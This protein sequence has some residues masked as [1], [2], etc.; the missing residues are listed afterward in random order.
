MKALKEKNTILEI[1]PKSRTKKQRKSLARF[2]YELA[3]VDKQVVQDVLNKFP[4]LNKKEHETIAERKRLQ[5]EVE[6]DE[7]K[8]ERYVKERIYQKTSRASRSDLLKES[9]NRQNSEKMKKMRS[10]KSDVE[11]KY[12]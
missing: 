8:E 5:R 6:T 4:Y 9:I 7:G 10:S 3:K 11:K 1:K 2:N 12:K